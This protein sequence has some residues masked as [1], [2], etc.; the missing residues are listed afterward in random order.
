MAA[1]LENTW[2]EVTSPYCLPSSG[3][4]GCQIDQLGSDQEL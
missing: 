4:S 2:S 3:N 1:S